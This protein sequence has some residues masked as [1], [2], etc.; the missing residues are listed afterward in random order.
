M[1]RPTN[2]YADA[3]QSPHGVG[4]TALQVTQDGGLVNKVVDKNSSGIDTVAALHARGADVHIPE[5]NP[6]P[7]HSSSSYSQ[8]QMGPHGAGKPSMLRA[9]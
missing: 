1:S 9:T 4:P 6:S 8:Y 7:V 2:P 5:T 3:H